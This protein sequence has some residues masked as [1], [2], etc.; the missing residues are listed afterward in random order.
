VNRFSILL[1]V[2]GAIGL[3]TPAVGQEYQGC[4]MINGVGR[5]IRLNDMCPQAQPLNPSTVSSS[6]KDPSTVDPGALADYYASKYCDWREAGG[7]SREESKQH[8]ADELSAFVRGVYGTAAAV[9]IF[10]QRGTEIFMQVDTAIQGR[11]P[12]EA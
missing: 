8:A 3:S 5:V 7:R 12:N 1:F 6:S 10:E 9:Q 4:F 2:L 11:C